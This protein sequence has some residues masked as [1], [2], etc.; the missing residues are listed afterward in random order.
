[1]L[2]LDLRQLCQLVSFPICSIATN[3][4]EVYTDPKTLVVPS[5]SPSSVLKSI[6]SNVTF[7]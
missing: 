7:L 6:M 4:K 3:I 5:R 1:M 2:S